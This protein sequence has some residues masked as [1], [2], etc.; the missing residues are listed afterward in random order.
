M[1]KGLQRMTRQETHKHLGKDFPKTIK[2]S[3]NLE[4]EEKFPSQSAVESSGKEEQIVSRYKNPGV[5]KY[6][7]QGCQEKYCVDSKGKEGKRQR[8]V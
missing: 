3:W 8:A 6:Y 5:F 7:I 1:R 4:D 2:L